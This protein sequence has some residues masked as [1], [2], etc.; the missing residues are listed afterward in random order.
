MAHTRYSSVS[1]GTHASQFG[2]PWHTREMRDLLVDD[3]VRSGR[4][5]AHTA[6]L[7][8]HADAN[9][10]TWPPNLLTNGLSGH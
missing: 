7:P 1:H 5:E 4:W 8:A 3:T 6:S 9:S 2:V 10:A